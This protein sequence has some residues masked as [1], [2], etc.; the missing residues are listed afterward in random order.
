M[1]SKLDRTAY[2][3]MES[4]TILCKTR[5]NPYVE[6]VHWVN[7]IVLSENTDFHCA[8]EHFEIDP[9]KLAKDLTNAMDR[10]PRGASSISDFANS[11][12]IAITEARMITSLVFNEPAI[13]TGHLLIALRN[14][15]ELSRCLL[16]MSKEFTKINADLLQENFKDITQA[17]AEISVVTPAGENAA[18]GQAGQM[19]EGWHGLG[20][21]GSVRLGREG[22]DSGHC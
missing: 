21:G 11:I 17:S 18:T 6:L 13:R 20:G 7:Q 19:G 12:E 15:Q 5:G 8:I 1:F 9:A 3:A 10:L 4:A 14:H 22:P 2:Q 16:D